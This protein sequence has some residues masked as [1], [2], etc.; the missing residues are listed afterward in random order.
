MK[1]ISRESIKSY[2]YIH[3]DFVRRYAWWIILFYIA[4]TALALYYT[5]LNLGVNSDTAE[6]F[7]PGLDFREQQEQFNRLFPLTDDNFVIVVESTVPEIA[8]SISRS[9][10]ERLRQEPELY[11]DVFLAGG[12]PFFK[13][14]QLLFLDYDELEDVTG[15][16]SQSYVFLSFLAQNYSLRGLFSLLDRVVAMGNEEQISRLDRLFAQIDS[17]IQANINGER[18]MLSWQRIMGGNIGKNASRRLIQVKAN[19]D[20]DRVIPS[21]PAIERARE[22]AQQWQDDR[23]SI[24]ITGQLAMSYEELKSVTEGAILSGILAFIL[25]GLTLWVGLRSL[26]LIIS[27][28][29]TLVI[30]LSLTMA[31][32]AATVGQ[33]NLISVAFA[34]LYIGLGVDYAIHFTLKFNELIR[35][36]QSPV[37]SLRESFMDLHPALLLSTFSTAFGFYAFLPTA[38]KGVS[39]LGLIAGTGMFISFVVTFTLLPALLNVL[40]RN[41]K[42]KKGSGTTLVAPFSR[43]IS[44]LQTNHTTLFRTAAF[45][46]AAGSLA[47]LP[48]LS[49]DYNPIN[50]RDPGTESVTVMEK[51]I[52]SGDFTPWTVDIVAPDSA[53]AEELAEK[54]RELPMVERTLNAYSFVP[55]RQEEK[56][57]M[58]RRLQTRYRRVPEISKDSASF[59]PENQVTAVHQLYRGITA[60]TK[61]LGTPVKNL[62][63]TLNSLYNY[64][65][66]IDIDKQ[67]ILINKIE[68]D[69]LKTFPGLLENLETAV[70]A[71]PVTLSDVPASLLDRWVTASGKY[72]IQVEPLAGLNENRELRAF[73][74]RIQKV[75][76]GATGT[77]VTT[78]KSSDTVVKAFIQALSYAL[79][80]IILLI[81]IYCRNLKQTIYILFPLLLAAVMTGAAM[82]LLDL[83]FNFANII[84]LP[85]IL[86]LGVDNGI[87]IVHRFSK[88][89]HSEQELLKTSTARAIFFSSLTTLF[90]FGNLAF[91]PHRGTSSMGIILTIGLLFMIFTTLI[92]LPAF[93][94]R[95]TDDVHSGTETD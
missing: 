66:S 8:D 39:E 40:F 17:T 47:L 34:V 32:S 91:S 52:D 2:W 24:Q 16:L 55:D 4:I 67:N 6:M 95:K 50:L 56:L 25:V 79:I 63:N 82:V 62:S 89:T 20:F 72:R 58:I 85:L 10:A 26:R 93:L 3:T 5:S 44:A 19:L 45:L 33:L 92:I 73:S 59:I 15:K 37:I 90:S 11:S 22:L 75:T 71:A 53:T 29:M 86:G 23:T 31:F 88:N 42:I 36:G 76:P 35:S 41:K 43:Q 49:F 61:A 51:L 30:G 78:I 68:R 80:I 70:D 64:L 28:V 84:A 94:T 27:A 74:S 1:F 21:K 46:A 77:L 83:Q 65:S 12:D 48:G 87:H 81:F 38:F 69:L 57:P 60:S 9:L 14:N 54:L 18:K 7:D 13:K